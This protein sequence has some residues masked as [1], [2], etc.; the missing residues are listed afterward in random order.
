MRG[1]GTINFSNLTPGTYNLVL[2]SQ[3]GT[4]TGAQFGTTFT[5]GG[6]ART[7]TENNNTAFTQGANYVEYTNLTVGAGGTLN[8]TFLATT[9]GEADFNGAQL[10]LVTAVPEPS[11]FAWMAVGI[12]ALMAFVRR[13]RLTA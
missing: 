4:Y 3:G 1:V 7:A 10:Q 12:G 5:F 2:Y 6:T 13:R 11:T 9:G 8:G